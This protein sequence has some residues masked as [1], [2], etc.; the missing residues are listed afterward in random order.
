MAVKILKLIGKHVPEAIEI[1][2]EVIM[3]VKGKK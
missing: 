3:L 1:V 2:I